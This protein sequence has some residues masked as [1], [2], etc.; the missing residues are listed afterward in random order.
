MIV[1]TPER[2]YRLG[3]TPPPLGQ[4]VVSWPWGGTP[5]LT[6]WSLDALKYPLGTIILDTVDGHPVVA[7][8]QTHDTYGAHPEWGVKLHKGTS[9]FVPTVVDGATGKFVAMRDPP[10]G[11]GVSPMGGWSEDA[12]AVMRKHNPKLHYVLLAGSTLAGAVVASLPGALVGFA[13]GLAH[14]VAMEE[15]LEHV[16]G[17]KKE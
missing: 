1:K 11:W 4:R 6:Q 2:E 9:V 7:Q 17:H 13:L 8:I 3:E 5:H 14:E 10:D 15:I 12:I 16:V